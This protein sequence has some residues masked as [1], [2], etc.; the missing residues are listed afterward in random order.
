[1]ISFVVEVFAV[2]YFAPLCN[3]IKAS[4]IVLHDNKSIHFVLIV[5][6]LC[7]LTLLLFVVL[8]FLLYWSCMYYVLSLS[9][10]L[11]DTFQAM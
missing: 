4:F 1:M 3:G 9:L 11:N 2:F 6:D 7:L 5:T 10:L 8:F